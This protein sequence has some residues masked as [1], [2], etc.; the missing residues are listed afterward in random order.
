MLSSSQH[1]VIDALYIPEIAKLVKAVA[2]PA[3]GDYLHA[4]KVLGCVRDYTPIFRSNISMNK[5]NA[6]TALRDSNPRLRKC[7][8]PQGRVMLAGCLKL[9][10]D[11]T[12]TE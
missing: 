2:D 5:V 8:T 12:A 7:F 3:E 6:F 9:K 1:E 4:L 11:S 10:L